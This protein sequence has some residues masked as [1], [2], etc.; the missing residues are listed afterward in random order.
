MTELDKPAIPRTRMSIL[1]MIYSGIAAIVLGVYLMA[2]VFGWE[3]RASARDRVP[4]TVRNSPGGYRGF[5]II[6]YHGGK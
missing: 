4:G 3:Q 2:G 5:W 6:G 1:I